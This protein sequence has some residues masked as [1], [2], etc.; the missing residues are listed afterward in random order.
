MGCATQDPVRSFAFSNFLG[1]QPRKFSIDF[2]LVG[3]VANTADEEIG[4]IADEKTVGRAP[5]HK[6]QI[7]SF[8]IRTSRTAA[9]TDFSLVMMGVSSARSAEEDLRGGIG[10]SK[11]A[12]APFT[13]ASLKPA[14]FNS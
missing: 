11:F 8:H 5:L 1:H 3:A 2:L 14:S 4:A 6:L 10:A 12:M 13:S 9:L 7:V